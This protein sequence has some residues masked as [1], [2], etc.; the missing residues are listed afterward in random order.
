MIQQFFTESMA[1][2]IIALAM[3]MA[4]VWFIQANFTIW[5]GQSIPLSLKDNQQLWIIF[6][7]IFILSSFVSALLPALIQSKLKSIELFKPSKSSGRKGG[8]RQSLVVFQFAASV[9]LIIGTLMVYQQINY[10]KNQELGVNID[11]MLT[12]YSPMTMIRK[13]QRIHKIETFKSEVSNTAGVK[14]LS[15]SSAIPGREIIWGSNNIRREGDS[16]NSTRSFNYVIID[17]DF[18]ENFELEIL[19]GRNFSI[20]QGNETESVILNEAALKQL[21]FDSYNDA[22]DQ[23]IYRGDTKYQIVG[24]V[25]DYHHQSLRHEIKPILFFYGYIWNHDV[26]YYAIKVRTDDIQNTVTSIERIWETI[27]PGDH[28]IYSFLDESFNNQYKTDQQFGEMFSIFTLLALTIAGMGLLAL[29]TYHIEQKNCRDRNKKSTRIYCKSNHVF[30]VQK[31]NS[32]G[33]ACKCNCLASGMVCHE[34]M[35]RRLC[36]SD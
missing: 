12:M 29:T 17:H 31:H 28:F 27:Y 15:T 33:C 13:P 7:S 30:T 19:V 35:V 10:M 1:T 11:Q 16:E 9:V 4:G 6:G 32:M 3:A 5:S 23:V 36:L 18:I 8:L 26:G 24:V 25:N 22:I 20:D 34:Q 14:S 2:N 21:G